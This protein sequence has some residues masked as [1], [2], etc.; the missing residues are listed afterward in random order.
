[1]FEG[2][3]DEATAFSFLVQAIDETE[4]PV[5]ADAV[6]T[7]RCYGQNG[8]VASGSGSAAF[9]E[10]G[11][12][13]GATNANPIVVTTTANHGITTGQPVKISG[14]LGNLAANGS[15]IAT[16]LS[17]TTFSIP[18]TGN[19]AYTSGGAWHST[20]LYRVTLAGSILSSLE[21][22]KTYTVVVTYAVGGDVKTEVHTFTVR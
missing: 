7:W 17:N 2:F 16:Y 14:V 20:G 3:A 1:M 10:S 18:A 4:A 19:G 8:L 15:F 22:G 9:A 12:L 21:A 11:N 5:D 6:P 13:S